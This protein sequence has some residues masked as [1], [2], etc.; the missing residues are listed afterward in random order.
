MLHMGYSDAIAETTLTI[1]LRWC[2]PSQGS[3]PFAD[4]TLPE[5]TGQ[6]PISETFICLATSIRFEV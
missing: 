1:P 6:L 4:D 5:Q 2:Y 3:C